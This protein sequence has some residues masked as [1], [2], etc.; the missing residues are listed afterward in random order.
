MRRHWNRSRYY[1][2]GR[3]IVE[4]PDFLSKGFH[5]TASVAETKRPVSQQPVGKYGP[6][7][8]DVVSAASKVDRQEMID[9]L[10]KLGQSMNRPTVTA[11]S[12]EEQSI[13]P[14]G[15][16]YLGQLIA[17]ELSF[18][19]TEMPAWDGLKP[20][21]YRSPQ[22]DLDSIYGRGPFHEPELY[23]DAA[24]LKVGETIASDY[25]R[26]T[27][28]NDLPRAGF[29]SENPRK[30]LI[31][32]PRNDDNLPLA[33]M[34]VAL[35]KFH[36]KVVDEL[37]RHNPFYRLCAR[38]ENRCP[39]DELFTCARKAVVQHF[40]AIILSDYLPNILDDSGLQRVESRNLQFYD[41]NS[42]EGMFMPLEFS[43]AAFR[44]GHSMV[45]SSYEWNYFHSG[46]KAPSLAHLFQFTQFSGD[47]GD[48][49]R[50]SSDWIIDWRRFFDFTEL[51]YTDDG[52]GFNFARK[53]DT[54]FNLHLDLIPGYP[55]GGFPQEQKAITVR[56]LLRGYSLDLPTGE[57]VVECIKPP[58]SLTRKEIVGG[59]HEA[60]LSDKI[61]E[62]RTPLWYYVLRE[63]QINKLNKNKDKLGPVGSCI[64]AETLLGLIKKSPDSIL[65]EPAWRPKFGKPLPTENQ[66]Y[67]MLD[68]LNYV[69]AVDPVGEYM[70]Y[71]K[72]AES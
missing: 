9:K 45:R 69:D 60:I 50:L 58:W 25:V 19:K 31:A 32:D 24:R 26:R 71:G 3:G 17:H 64:V 54:S 68:L 42:Y 13:I 36:N 59:P 55:H 6:M 63:A 66:H 21:N 4:E 46:K 70:D 22:I 2:V 43:V 40:Q 38:H 47:L 5:P 37:Q 28:L 35:A 16:T 1:V 7:F 51:G 39:P 44:F 65:N 41:I 15:Y 23:E 10:I 67:R 61:F 14:S 30:A 62:G 53:I 48:T 29:G 34:H 49:P 27:F 33:Q 12:V 52:R 57:Q 56:N 18:D 8:R 11:G 20:W 72:K